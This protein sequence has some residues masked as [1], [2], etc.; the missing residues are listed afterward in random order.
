MALLLGGLR[1]SPEMP[2]TAELPPT[3]FRTTASLAQPVTF[4]TW[5]TLLRRFTRLNDASQAMAGPNSECA[6]ESGSDGNAVGSPEI[7]DGGD[8]VYSVCHTEEMH[9]RKSTGM[10]A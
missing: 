8:R 7:A 2:T 4:P 6:S 9:R 10:K 3:T 5:E 1:S